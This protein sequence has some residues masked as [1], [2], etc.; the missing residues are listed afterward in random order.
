MLT[1]LTV[2]QKKERRTKKSPETRIDY[3]IGFWIYCV[4]CVRNTRWK[5]N[6]V[7][8]ITYRL[9]HFDLHIHR[10]FEHST[11]WWER[12]LMTLGQEYIWYLI[13]RITV[14]LLVWCA[15]FYYFLASYHRS[16][17]LLSALKPKCLLVF[18]TENKDIIGQFNCWFW[19]LMCRILQL[20]ALNT[21]YF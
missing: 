8:M 4:H 17:K 11:W 14:C 16:A 5:E 9:R 3:E 13:W 12:S 7:M 2:T 1:K 21:R 20:G 6:A 15:S 10:S 19:L 18:A